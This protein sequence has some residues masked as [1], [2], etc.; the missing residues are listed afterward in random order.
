MFSEFSRIFL[1][2]LAARSRAMKHTTTAL[3]VVVAVMCAPQCA[4]EVVDETYGFRF[5]VPDGFS[6]VEGNQFGSRVLYST[7]K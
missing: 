7:S 4:E 3:S 2:L 5:D 6:P 1:A